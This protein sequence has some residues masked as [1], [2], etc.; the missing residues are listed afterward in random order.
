[1]LLSSSNPIHIKFTLHLYSIIRHELFIF[2]TFL[3]KTIDDLCK[4]FPDSI[5]ISQTKG[6]QHNFYKVFVNPLLRLCYGK[7]CI[8]A[9]I[10]KPQCCKSSDFKRKGKRVKLKWKRLKL[11]LSWFH[12]IICIIIPTIFHLLGHQ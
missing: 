2:Y 9:T 6:K 8:A 12:Y 10:L 3:D 11:E 4:I 1:M 7:A 5:D